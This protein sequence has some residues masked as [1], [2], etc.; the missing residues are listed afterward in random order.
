MDEKVKSL[1]RAPNFAHVATVRRDGSAA[2][3]PMWVDL[4]EDLVLING[5]TGRTWTRRLIRDPRVTMTV[6]A[7]ANPYECATLRGYALPPTIEDAGDHMDRLHQKYRNRPI[8][9][10]LNSLGAAQRGTNERVLFRVVVESASYRYEPP[11]GATAD[12]YDAF[13]A[14]FI[15]SMSSVPKPE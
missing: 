12:E 5:V 11:P 1:L 9:T 4:E 8:P 7:L 10:P 13:L 15:S 6:P 3:T 14:E 2:V